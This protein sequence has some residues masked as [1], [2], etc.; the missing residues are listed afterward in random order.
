MATLAE[1]LKR[2]REKEAGIIWADNISEEGVLPWLFL[3]S[4]QDA[5]NRG[6][7]KHHGITHVLNVADDVPNFHESDVELTY[8]KL[9]VGDFGTDAGISRVFTSAISFAKS[10]RE[11]QAG[12]LLVHC[13]N[14]SNRSP[15][16]VTA[17]CVELFGMTL[18]EAWEHVRTRHPSS[19]LLR[20]N[21]VELVEWD[22]CRRA[23]AHPA[24][25][26]G[27]F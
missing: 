10:C 16:V 1:A 20:D 5:S 4:G 17:I 25:Q 12:V 15:A 24:M 14:G 26:E 3:G 9:D 11:A 7:L 19:K 21:R 13:A 18:P 2:R 6:Q 22:K 27:G 23:S 8:C